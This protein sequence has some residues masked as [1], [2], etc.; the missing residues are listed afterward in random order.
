VPG[1]LIDHASTPEDL[2]TLVT[3]APIAPHL[4]SFFDQSGLR[5]IRLI[6]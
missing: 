5:V 3:F 6:Q 1:F 4:L 2:G